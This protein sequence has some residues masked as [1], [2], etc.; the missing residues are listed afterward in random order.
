VGASGISRLS[1]A[2]ELQSAQGADNPHGAAAPE[3]IF[4][5][6]LVV[7]PSNDM[8]QQVKVAEISNLVKQKSFLH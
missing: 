3:N 8:F 2:A 7:F 4:L 6:V 5:G 1:G